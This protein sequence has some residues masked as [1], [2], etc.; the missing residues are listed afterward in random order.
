[1]DGLSGHNILL[2]TH[3]L[4]HE[5]T[6]HSPGSLYGVRAVGCTMEGML[7]LAWLQR[8]GEQEARG[9][10]ISVVLLHSGDRPTG[11]G[12]FLQYPV[13]EGPL[14]AFPATQV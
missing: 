9:N 2:M 13:A 7:H 5:L 6:S 12:P 1:M 10:A 14:P 3:V 8:C 4:S 11:V